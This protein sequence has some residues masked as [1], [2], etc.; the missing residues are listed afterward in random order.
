MAKTS[1]RA[2]L[3][4]LAQFDTPSTTNVVATYP[5]NPLCLGLYHPW[6]ENWSVDGEL[7]HRPK[8]SVHVSGIG[9]DGRTCGDMRF[10]TARSQL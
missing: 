1:N 2:L 8:H 10:W 6:T 7:V 3:K 5:N 4:K 9:S